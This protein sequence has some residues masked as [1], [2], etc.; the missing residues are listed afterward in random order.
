MRLT[1]EWVR[2][3]GRARNF[4]LLQDDQTGYGAHPDFNL[5]GIRVYPGGKP[6]G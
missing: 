6:A 4:Y 5:I 2:I 3:P 1:T